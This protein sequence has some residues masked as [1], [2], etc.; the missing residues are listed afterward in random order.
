MGRPE[1]EPYGAHHFA[2]QMVILKRA[3]RERCDFP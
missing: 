3:T 2:Q 1:G